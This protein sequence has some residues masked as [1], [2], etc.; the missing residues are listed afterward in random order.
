MERLRKRINLALCALILVGTLGTSAYL[1][2]TRPEPAQVVRTEPIPE[3]EVATVELSTF[4]APVVGHGNVRAKSPLRI[5]PEVGGT[6]KYVHPNLAVGTSCGDPTV[7]DCTDADTCDGA[8]TCLAN[9]DA[10]GTACTD[11]GNECTSDVCDGAGSCIHPNLT[12]GTASD[13]ATDSRRLT[14]E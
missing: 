9:D 5:V 11:E 6:L 8:G 10:V 2:V 12:D 7:D 3:V 1:V 4:D 13:K 14:D